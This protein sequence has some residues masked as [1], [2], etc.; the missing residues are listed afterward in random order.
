MSTSFY[1]PAFI[2]LLCG[3]IM[4][5][6]PRLVCCSSVFILLLLLSHSISA[7]LYPP[8]FFRQSSFPAQSWSSGYMTN[9]RNLIN[10]NGGSL[11][12]LSDQSSLTLLPKPM[13]SSPSFFNQLF[14]TSIY[15]GSILHSHT[16]SSSKKDDKKKKQNGNPL[17]KHL[18]F[19]ASEPFG[20]FGIPL[21]DCTPSHENE[22]V[23]LVVEICT[24]VIEERGL[25][26]VGIYRVPGNKA[27]VETLKSELQKVYMRPSYL[28]VM[29]LQCKLRFL[30]SIQG[31][32]NEENEK[33][34]DV[35]VMSS[36]LKDFLR[37]LPDSLITAKMYKTFIETNRIDGSRERL[38]ALRNLLRKL[39]DTNYETLKY[40][41]I[42]LR[43]VAAY[44]S[45]NKVG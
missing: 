21:N 27:A 45:V 39:P 12:F 13:V 25:E 11:V 19:G 23:P 18:V 1:L 16:D 15:P 22:F 33:W 43:K 8:P 44:G 9:I 35:N 3:S 41:A 5:L 40:L 38:I 6:L 4:G 29:Y 26:F 20:D 14:I 10:R 28:S 34:K 32:I 24:K 42:H 17:P 2:L 37:K 7:P 31:V 30:M 36:L